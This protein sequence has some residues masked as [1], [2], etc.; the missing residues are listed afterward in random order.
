MIPGGGFHVTKAGAIHRGWT[1]PLSRHSPPL[2]GPQPRAMLNKQSS[3][4]GRRDP[5]KSIRGNGS[6]PVPSSTCYLDP[7][8]KAGK[9]QD[10]TASPAVEAVSQA[11]CKGWV[12]QNRQERPARLWEGPRAAGF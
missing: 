8:F 10:T 1:R 7:V 2:P 9:E 5:E 3:P 4:G 11:V 12:A 6:T